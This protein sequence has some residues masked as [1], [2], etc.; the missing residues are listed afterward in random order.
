MI[1][2]DNAFQIFLLVADHSPIV[3]SS[4][5]TSEQSFDLFSD[6][7][8]VSHVAQSTT[9]KSFSQN[10]APS[11]MEFDNL[12]FTPAS[13]N[14]SKGNI[15]VS[16]TNFLLSLYDSQPATIHPTPNLNIGNVG[17]IPKANY[18]GNSRIITQQTANKS[19]TLGG[20]K[21]DPFESLSVFPSK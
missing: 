15:P 1:N 21:N 19:K 18:Q 2:F 17:I 20:K 12:S 13:S 14:N 10:N 4:Q 9:Q 7:N 6:N 5:Y 16:D 11:L 3:Q 8:L